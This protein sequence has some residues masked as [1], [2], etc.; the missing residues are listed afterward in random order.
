MQALH[1]LLISS[2]FPQEVCKVG[3]MAAIL[4]KRELKLRKLNSIELMAEPRSELQ[5][6]CFQSIHPSVYIFCLVGRVNRGMES[7]KRD[8]RFLFT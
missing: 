2:L 6:S 8:V 5:S 1:H 7:G 3:V 4:P